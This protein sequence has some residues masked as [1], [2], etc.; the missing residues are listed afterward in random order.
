MKISVLLESKHGHKWLRLNKPLNYAE[1]IEAAV[2]L[3]WKH[4]WAP[5]SLEN[6]QCYDGHPGTTIGSPLQFFATADCLRRAGADLLAPGALA[7]PTVGNLD[8]GVFFELLE[9]GRGGRVLRHGSDITHVE[10]GRG[11]RAI[12]PSSKLVRS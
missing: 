4:G 5:E 10:F 7:L 2:L 8:P 1:A 3:A 6:A 11:I 9:G 12:V